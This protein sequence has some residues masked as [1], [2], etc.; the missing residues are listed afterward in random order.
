ML[1]IWITRQDHSPPFLTPYS[2]PQPITYPLRTKNPFTYKHLFLF[3]RLTSLVNFPLSLKF[4][5]YLSNQ[6]SVNERSPILLPNDLTQYLFFTTFQTS[7]YI[8]LVSHKP[9]A[10]NIPLSNLPQTH[11]RFFHLLILTHIDS[12][13]FLNLHHNFPRRPNLR[14]GDFQCSTSYPQDHLKPSPT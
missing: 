12:N 14:F 3:Y 2:T 9:R 4:S 6:K 11:A 5:I 7:Y 10:S 8:P 13:L 1:I